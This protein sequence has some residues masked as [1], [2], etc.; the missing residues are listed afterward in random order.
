MIFLDLLRQPLIH[1]RLRA[2]W[3][4][5]RSE[6]GA[7]FVIRHES[8]GQVP[9]SP[10]ASLSEA[11]NT[12]LA[13]GA[14]LADLRNAAVA[15]AGGQSAA[16]YLLWLQ[17]LSDL[18]LIE[19][20]LV[21]DAGEQA[22]ILPQRESWVPA[23]APEEPPAGASLDRFA[24]LRRDGKSWVLESPLAGA[25]F[26]FAD[27]AVLDAPLVR[28]ALDAAGFLERRSPVPEPRRNALA[29]WEFHDLIFHGH[30]HAGLHR[31]P[32]GALFPF[33]GEI[34]PPPAARPPW[35]G[36]RIALPRAP[37]EPDGESF[38]S[39]LERRRSERFYDE[40]HP[41]SLRDVGALLDRCA[42]IR[43]FSTV[44]VANFTGRSCDFG[45]TRR[46]YPNG[47]ASYEL[48]IYAVVDRCDGL[49]SGFYHYDAVGHALVRVSERTPE[50]ERFIAEGHIATA[51]QAD[52]QVLLVIAARFARVMW[53]YKS[54]AYAV[55]LRNT[56][57]LYQTLYLAATE[58]GIS[59]CGV[60]SGNTALF[61]QATG[62]DPLIEGAVG[63]F[64]LGG[65]PRAP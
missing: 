28:R 45:I 27:L 3:R 46:P 64:I 57:A 22:L 44:E 13:G 59:P 20:A 38:A 15:S 54:I 10:H 43:S 53:K 29:Q 56:G 37:R 52:P 42:R 4:L 39:V 60:G 32:L 48:E 30:C 7:S 34:D 25:R 26:V 2:G 18:A 51:G 12:L 5:G 35:P 24:C 55:I 9:V 6:D 16:L 1:V 33:I 19:F 23:L 62:L 58:M 63:E 14:P 21:D 41:I 11:A 36:E 17:R 61:A 50:V 65:R 49:E 40:D 47:G 8:W 31:D